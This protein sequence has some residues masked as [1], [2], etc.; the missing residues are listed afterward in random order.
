MVHDRRDYW[1]KPIP[2]REFSIN[3]YTSATIWQLKDLIAKTLGTN[4]R[5]VGLELPEKTMVTDDMNGMTLREVN[6]KPN[7]VILVTRR[8][9][10]DRHIEKATLMQANKAFTPPAIKIIKSLFH[11]YKDSDT[12]RLT[13]EQTINLLQRLARKE[14][15]RHDE[16]YDK[17]IGKPNDEE[18][19]AEEGIKETAF[20]TSFHEYAKMKEHHIHR[21]FK[22]CFWG[23]DFVRH[24]D[25]EAPPHLEA[26]KMP[27]YTISA[28]EEQF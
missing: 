20:L 25:M 28:N 2:D 16:L 9:L 18:E 10:P 4:S 3:T 26:C 5:Y 22:S 14:I 12:G 11:A 7:S 1:C 15:S 8:G 6:L 24:V 13:K 19:N 21:Y 17:F 23:K 27:R